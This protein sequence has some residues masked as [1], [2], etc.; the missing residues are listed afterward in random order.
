MI[1]DIIENK[2]NLQR[3]QQEEINKVVLGNEIPWYFSQHSVFGDNLSYFSHVLIH[4]KEQK[5]N[6]EHNS[7]LTNF[8]ID[9]L[10]QILK[11]NSIAYN[12]ILRASLNTTFF[13]DKPTGTVH[14][15]HD[16]EHNNFIMYL[17]DVSDAGTVIYKENDLTKQYITQSNQFN[18]VIFPGFKHAQLF[19]LPGKRRTVFV[20]TFE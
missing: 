4:R 17:E 5:A 11:E 7:P 18:Y 12:E 2:A 20:A 3:W 1:K 10:Q 8:F 19:P 9:I 13:N 14:L 16:F 15:D 6:Q